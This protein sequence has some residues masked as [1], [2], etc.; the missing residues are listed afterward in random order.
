ML[1][2]SYVYQL[3]TGYESA[4][5]NKLCV[6]RNV[7]SIFKYAYPIDNLLKIEKIDKF[8]VLTE[9]INSISGYYFT[10][11]MVCA[12]YPNEHDPINETLVFITLRDEQAYLEIGTIEEST[13][14]EIVE[15]LQ[16]TIPVKKR[17]EKESY[18]MNF[19][20]HGTTGPKNNPRE[21]KE[22]KL[23][24]IIDNY[25]EEDRG[26]IEILKNYRPVKGGELLLLTG[27]A[28]V[29]KSN[30]LLSLF[31]EWKDWADFNYILDQQNFFGQSPSYILDLILKP[32]FK[33][34]PDD[35]NPKKFKN[36]NYTSIYL[37]TDSLTEEKNE[38]KWKI[39]I[40]E[41]AGE[42]LAVDA[43]E[44]VGQALSMFLNVTDGFVGRGSKIILILTTNEDIN[45]L[46]PAVSRPGRCVFRHKFGKMSTSE[47]IKWAAG[48]KCSNK[49]V[50]E[51]SKSRKSFSLAE[52]YALKNEKLTIGDLEKT[53]NTMGFGA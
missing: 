3:E 2:I 38:E 53:K 45:K 42:M 10:R 25:N 21:F 34:T 44:K 29:G 47:S 31:R 27:E 18:N 1:N 14:K 40:L 13:I 35:G 52:L 48:H 16:K 7:N 12:Y 24:D 15:T 22:E 36:E 17:K 49:L 28:G 8:K 41:D 43:K 23:D 46:H 32:I 4:L 20:Y 33:E 51:I 19:W 50:N 26:K 11:Y 5:F 30:L 9:S 39:F 6:D 37:N